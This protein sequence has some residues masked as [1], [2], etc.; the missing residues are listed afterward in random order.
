MDK[1]PQRPKLINGKVWIPNTDSGYSKLPEN[2]PRYK[3]IYNWIE[4]Q[5]YVELLDWVY[6]R[7]GSKNPHR[8]GNSNG[9]KNGES[10]NG[11]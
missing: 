3:E 1:A 6:N 10:K 4:S 8:N 7:E 5:R 2:D 11:H 9:H